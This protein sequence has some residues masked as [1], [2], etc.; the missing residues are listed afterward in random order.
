MPYRAVSNERGRV[1]W[2][3]VVA[4]AVLVA[5][6][7]LA[8]TQW[9]PL[10]PSIAPRDVASPDTSDAVIDEALSQAPVDSAELKSRW[11]DEVK[12]IDVSMLTAKQLDIFVRYANAE[13]CTC[14]CGFTLA[15]CRTFDPTCPVSQPRVEA[16]RDSVASG[17]IRNA[18]G[19]RQRPNSRG[20]G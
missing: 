14:G 8:I 20:S 4:L 12:D 7:A 3:G 17:K 11:M 2:V 18:V 9:R 5:G 6:V 19:L 1:R 16:L 10:R 13:R 15:A